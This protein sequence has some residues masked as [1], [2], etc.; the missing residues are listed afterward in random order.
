MITPFLVKK[1]DLSSLAPSYS[2]LF[3]ICPFLICSL[4]FARHVA[5]G[6]K[7]PRA[8]LQTKSAR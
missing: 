1:C 5:D 7:Y 8:L 2:L 4:S 6:S 3:V